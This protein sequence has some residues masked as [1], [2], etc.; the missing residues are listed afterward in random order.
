MTRQQVYPIYC[1]CCEKN[2][3]DDEDDYYYCGLQRKK[4][5]RNSKNGFRSEWSLP[6]EISSCE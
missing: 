5:M 1:D 2:E 3:S 6:Y 4:R